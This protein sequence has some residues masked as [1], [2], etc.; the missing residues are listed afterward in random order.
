MA[1]V[2]ITFKIMLNSPDTNI[3]DVENIVTIIIEDYGANVGRIEIEPVAFG[4]KALNITCIMD[5]SKGGTDK[6]ED[7]I[8]EVEGVKSVD[9]VDVRRAFG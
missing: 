8:R 3:E 5:E 2:I 7:L 1:N 9:V 4:L 6:L